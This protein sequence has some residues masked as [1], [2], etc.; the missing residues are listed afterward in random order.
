MFHF[1][2]KI[3]LNVFGKSTL[4]KL[5]TS[6]LQPF[7]ASLLSRGLLFVK[8]L[9]QLKCKHFLFSLFSCFTIFIQILVQLMFLLLCIKLLQC[10]CIGLILLRLLCKTILKVSY[11]IIILLISWKRESVLISVSLQGVSTLLYTS[12]DIQVEFII[13]A[14]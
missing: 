3:F 9:H 11:L 10:L 14:C 4:T 6:K 7:S 2:K 1:S 12:L 8:I 5:G 13:S